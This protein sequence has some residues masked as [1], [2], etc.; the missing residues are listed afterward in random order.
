MNI[1]EYFPNQ[2]MNI[3]YFQGY[4]TFIQRQYL[5]ILD[6]EKPTQIHH[7]IPRT[8]FKRGLISSELQRDCDK[9]LIVLSVYNHLKAHCILALAFPNDAYLSSAVEFMKGIFH[10]L[11]T[12]E[13][14]YAVYNN[15]S[16]YRSQLSK[17]NWKNEEY[18]KKQI[19][20]R[21]DLSY[22][23]KL[24]DAIK[25]TKTPEMNAYNAEKSRQQWQDT[26]MRKKN[27]FITGEVWNYPGYRESKIR[28]VKAQW[29]DPSIRK[30]MR[31]GI[32][33]SNLE[34]AKKKR[35]EKESAVMAETMGFLF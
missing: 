25:A 5:T 30:K 3:K 34:Y 8:L 22:R 23:Q 17:N 10:D 32:S 33:A 31:Q 19:S 18:I 24:S 6:D 21:S 35:Q 26:E 13:E 7:I 14:F 27:V 16:E 29:Q 4:I 28:Q 2:G 20:I 15:S 12:P 11:P 9:N 1:F